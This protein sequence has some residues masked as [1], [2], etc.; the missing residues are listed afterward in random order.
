MLKKTPKF[1]FAV[2]ASGPDPEQDVTLDRFHEA[3]CDD[4]TI[5]FQNGRFVVAFTREAATFAEAVASAVADVAKAGAKV[6]RIEP[7]PL[8]SLSDMAARTGLSRAAM[9]NYFKGHRAEAFPPPVAKV[10]SES[11]LW[12]WATV[13]RWMFEHRRIERHAAIQAEIVREANAAIAEGDMRLARRLQARA[14][15]YAKELGEGGS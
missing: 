6:E 14:R 3:G 1:E 13:A 15:R 2:I 9:T 5:A 10:T 7:D 8:V 11:P 4:A 12:D